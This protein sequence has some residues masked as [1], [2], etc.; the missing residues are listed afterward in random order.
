MK[1]PTKTFSVLNSFINWVKPPEIE[2]PACVLKTL[3]KIYPTIDWKKVKFYDGLPWFTALF[4]PRTNAI[5]LPGTYGFHN[6][7]I[8]F[9]KFD[10]YTTKGI[11]TVI[12]EGFH[13]LQFN[14]IG[15]GKVSWI[16]KFMIQYLGWC[17][18]L[19]KNCYVNHPMEK[20]AYEFESRFSTRYKSLSQPICGGT[21]TLP[22]FHPAAL[23]ELINKHPSLIQRSSGY[24]P[25]SFS[26]STFPATLMVVFMTLFLPVMDGIFILIASVIILFSLI[27]SPFVWIIKSIVST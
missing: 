5:T 2:K 26:W 13:V 6:I 17:I 8:H 27:L 19:G 7:V 24:I 15:T 9:K 25:K 14:E 4:A 21:S 3:E 20:E 11:S 12:H 23:A 16:R 18:K 10:P 1:L 22:T